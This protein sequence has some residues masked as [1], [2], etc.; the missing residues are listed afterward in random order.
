M[1][2][3][4]EAS[5][6]P[7]LIYTPNCAYSRFAAYAAMAEQG[8]VARPS[9]CARTDAIVVGLMRLGFRIGIIFDSANTVLSARPVILAA[10][11][12]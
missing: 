5:W 7:G 9:V 1:R 11:T 2:W 6:W 4:R 3:T 12:F 8:G 10:P